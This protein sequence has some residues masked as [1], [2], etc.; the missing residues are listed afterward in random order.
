[1]MGP[2]LVSQREGEE[3]LINKSSVINGHSSA[4]DEMLAL[5]Q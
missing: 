5:P 3:L 4:A 1:M 2:I